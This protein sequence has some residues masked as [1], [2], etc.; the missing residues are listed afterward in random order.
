MSQT[1]RFAF[2]SAD[3]VLS[4]DLA[5]QIDRESSGKIG[6]LR[7]FSGTNRA[8][9]GIGFLNRSSNP[10]FLIR[11]AVF[12]GQDLE[13]CPITQGGISGILGHQPRFYAEIAV[14]APDVHPVLRRT[15]QWFRKKKHPRTQIRGRLNFS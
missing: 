8:S 2:C 10:R 4:S 12:G 14:G 13:K 3:P 5:G 15:S 11:N 7:A 1:V 9:P 6:H